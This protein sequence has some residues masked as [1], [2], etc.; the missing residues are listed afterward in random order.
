MYF[1]RHAHFA[2]LVLGRAVAV[3]QATLQVH[4]QDVSAR[5]AAVKEN[6]VLWDL[7]GTEDMQSVLTGLKV[8]I[9]SP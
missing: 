8:L 5:G 4:L 2:E 7:Q 6:I 9:N 3:Q 1:L